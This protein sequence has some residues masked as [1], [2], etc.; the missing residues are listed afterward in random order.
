MRITFLC[1]NLRISGGV[2]A[3]LTYADRLAVRRHRVD[4]I[5]P[6]RRKIRAFWR[7]LR[8]DKPEWLREFHARITFVD[9]WRAR[10]LPRADVCVATAWPSAPVVAAASPRAGTKF[11]FVQGY[12]SLFAGRPEDVDPTYRLPPR[13]IVISTWLRDLIREKFGHDSEVI[14]TP[15]DL[16]LFRRVPAHPD[17]SHPRVLILPKAKSPPP[18]GGGR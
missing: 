9:A 2:R 3:I 10:S 15:V 7:T 17:T 4:V 11:Y 6:V 5:V 13:K 1:P 12:E 14:V 18:P 16:G 8:G